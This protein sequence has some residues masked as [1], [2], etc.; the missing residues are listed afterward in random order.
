MKT[1]VILS[2]LWALSSVCCYADGEFNVGRAAPTP[3]QASDAS[4]DKRLPP[5]LPGE[6]VAD[7]ERTM[8]VWSSSGPVSVAQPPEPFEGRAERK[9][10]EGISRGAMGVVVDGRGSDSAVPHTGP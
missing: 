2:L 10:L 7:G 9:V 6:E 5:V 1:A 4:F 8:R 3:N